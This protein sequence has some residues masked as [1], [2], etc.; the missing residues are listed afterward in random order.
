MDGTPS[1]N[2]NEGCDANECRRGPRFGRARRSGRLAV[3]ARLRSRRRCPGRLETGSSRPFAAIPDPDCDVPCRS[4]SRVLL[5]HDDIRR[6]FGLSPVRGLGGNSS[7]TS[8][9][10]ALALA[11]PRLP[12]VAE[13]TVASPSSAARSSSVLAASSPKDCRCA[14]RPSVSVSAKPRSM[15]P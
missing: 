6:T 11:S 1:E 10:N 15:P 5:R 8:F 13:R 14:K 7:A 2:Q 12:R 9:R 3:R 4:W